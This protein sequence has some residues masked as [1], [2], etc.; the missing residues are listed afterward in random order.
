MRR[1]AV[2]GNRS[3]SGSPGRKAAVL[4][5]PV[6]HS[7][8]PVLHLA[9]YR[10]LGLPGW[11]YQRLESDA[12]QLPGLLDGLGPEWAGVSVTMPGKHAALEFATEATER[13][14]AVGAANTLVNLGSGRWRA[15]CTDVDGVAGALLAVCGRPQ[16]DRPAVVLG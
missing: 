10:A 7:L 16:L 6:E 4:G 2:S 14:R 11:S 3:G 9:A 1:N 13:A 5:K 8:S 12:A 15:D